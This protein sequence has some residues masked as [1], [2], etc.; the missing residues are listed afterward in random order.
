[1]Q[2]W[3]ENVQT[4]ATEL[5]L[6]LSGDDIDIVKTIIDKKWLPIDLIVFAKIQL[7][8]QAVEAGKGVAA[9]YQG[10]LGSKA[11]LRVDGD[12]RCVLAP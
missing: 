8:D 9:K 11:E 10:N 1:M 2:L 12:R 7:A 4:T 3:V 6:G 5:G